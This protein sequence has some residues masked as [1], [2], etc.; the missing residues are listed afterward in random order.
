MYASYKH[1]QNLRK[2][3][4][5]TPAREAGRLTTDLHLFLLC[6]KSSRPLHLTL[7]SVADRLL[8]PPL[9]SVSISYADLLPP[10]SPPIL[11]SQTLIPAG[12][13]QEP[14][15][16]PTREARRPAKRVV[17]FRS[18]PLHIQSSCLIPSYAAGYLLWPLLTLPSFPE[19]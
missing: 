9:L 8:C 19:D 12:I 15:A 13:L 5:L 14:P 11:L 6:S 18:L 4:N 17:S 2:K 10:S 7:H 1:K 16:K 3:L